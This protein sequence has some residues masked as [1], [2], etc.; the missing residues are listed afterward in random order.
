MCCFVLF[1]FV[2]FASTLEQ[3]SFMMEAGI[4][5]HHHHT[6]ILMLCWRMRGYLGSILVLISTTTCVLSQVAVDI[7]CCTQVYISLYLRSLSRLYC[8]KMFLLYSCNFKKA[9]PGSRK[10]PNFHLLLLHFQPALI[11]IN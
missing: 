4:R 6:S 11:H 1:A 9:S 5:F 10:V 3:I 8:K 7:Y 2:S